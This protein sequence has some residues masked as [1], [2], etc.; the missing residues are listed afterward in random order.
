MFTA[1]CLPPVPDRIINTY[2]YLRTFDIISGTLQTIIA[3]IKLTMEPFI[4]IFK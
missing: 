3:A 4:R 2:Y 1:A